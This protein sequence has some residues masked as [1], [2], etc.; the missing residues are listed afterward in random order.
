M[1][2]PTYRS[3]CKLDS[4]SIIIV[5]SISPLSIISSF[6]L[7]FLSFFPSF[8]FLFLPP[9]RP[10]QSQWASAHALA[11]HCLLCVWSSC[12]RCRQTLHSETQLHK[13]AVDC[14]CPVLIYIS[15]VLVKTCQ[16]SHIPSALMPVMTP[17]SHSF[18]LGMPLMMMSSQPLN[19]FLMSSPPSLLRPLMQMF[20]S[21]IYRTDMTD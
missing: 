12:S 7:F 14:Q 17:R 19:T 15:I 1:V 8:H 21:G 18:F 16:L 13:G 20:R 5:T 11:W 4:L 9:N 6:L 2:V 3:A 10:A